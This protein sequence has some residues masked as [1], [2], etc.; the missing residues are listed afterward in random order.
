MIL[1]FVSLSLLKQRIRWF[2]ST[3]HLFST[4]AKISSHETFGVK[5]TSYRKEGEVPPASL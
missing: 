4:F 3:L 5:L 2:V 1:N